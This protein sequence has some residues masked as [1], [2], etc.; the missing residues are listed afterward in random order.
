MAKEC[1]RLRSVVVV[2]VLVFSASGN[3]KN[4]LVERFSVDLN[5]CTLIIRVLSL[6]YGTENFWSFVLLR[7]QV[8]LDRYIA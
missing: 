8:L 1:L 7:I 6:E 4:W 3:W 2:M 5:L